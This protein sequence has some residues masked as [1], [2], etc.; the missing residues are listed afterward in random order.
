[1]VMS[2]SKMLL[3]SE[4]EDASRESG[5]PQPEG[6]WTHLPAN[7]LVSAGLSTFLKGGGC[8]SFNGPVPQLVLMSCR[9]NL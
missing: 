2:I 3:V 4:I 8:S 5:R 1:M 7:H 9:Q 6:F